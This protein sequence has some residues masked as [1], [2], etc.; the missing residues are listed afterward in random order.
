MMPADRFISQT[1]LRNPRD[2][3]RALKSCEGLLPL[4]DDL[5]LLSRC[6]DAIAAKA[7]ASTPTALF[8]WPIADDARDGDRR[9]RR[10]GHLEHG[11]G[12]EV[13]EG[14]LIAY[15][16]R[17]IPGL[18]RTGRHVGGG[19]GAVAAPPSSDGEQKALLETVIAN[20]PEETIKSSAHTGTAVGATTARILFGLL[21]MVNI[22]HA[23]EAS[24]DMLE[25]RTA[26]RLPD[27]AV[28]DLLIPS[29]SY[30]VGTL[31]DV[32]CVERIVPYFLEG[33]DVAD[34]G[35]EE[36]GSEAETPGRE[37]SR[38][39][40]LAVGRLVDAY[41]GEIATDAYLKPD[42]FCDLAWA[43]PDGARVYD[44]GLYRAVDIYLKAHPGLSEE[45]KEKEKVSGVVDGRKL[46]L[47]AC[48]HA[49]QNE[50]LPLRT[51]VQ[52]LF[53]EQLQL[54][55]A[56]AR[57]ITANEGGAAGSGEEGDESDGGGTWRVAARGNQ[58]LRLDMDSMRNRV[59]ELERECTSMR[60]AIDKMDRRGGAP[61]DRG[62]PSVPADGRWG[63]IVTKRFGCKFPAQVCQS[64]QRTV[65]ART[66]RPRIEQ[67]P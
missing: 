9:R 23:S 7:A 48:T 18:S 43:L 44:D 45:E 54:R 36:E 26:A 27:A 56:I 19:G 66:R 39:A 52:V 8:G 34:E 49:A 30:L 22:L 17:S 11:V 63:A 16:K 57:T 35:N 33:R 50:R 58:M 24:R 3:I 53:F 51:V 62:A 46:T 15:A 65:V 1:V 55:R 5:G 38:R 67:S 64:Q 40:M 59:Q 20:L 28:D 37:A 42:K 31:Y 41:L 14:A 25:R 21:R 47:E 61:V 10:R 13:I 60:K 32:D 4:A 29:Y 12:P 2:A 6:V